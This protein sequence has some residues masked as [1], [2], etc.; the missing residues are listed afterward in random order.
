M[1]KQE[2][3]TTDEFGASHTGSVGV[4]LAGGTVPKPAYIMMTEHGAGLTT[5]QWTVY[6][7]HSRLAPRAHA[8]R[9]VCSCGW[10]GPE[11]PLD[12]GQIGEQRLGEA[13]A[14]PA[15]T[16]EQEWDQHTVEVEKSAVALPEDLA[17]V[18]HGLGEAIE[19]LAQNSPLAAL[20]AAR[21]L[22]VTAERTAYWPAHDARR[23]LGLAATAAAL[24]LDE[25]GARHLLARFGRWSPYS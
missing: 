3:W 22:E 21:L 16:C 6:D 4:L 18:L 11:H 10:S 5:A 1:V 25:D 9:A 23:D 19:K 20:R 14:E 12:W 17:E 7:G 24:G 8:L 15:D 2:T 13:A